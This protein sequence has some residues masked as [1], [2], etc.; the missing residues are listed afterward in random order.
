MKMNYAESVDF[1]FTQLAAYQKLGK[2][3]LQFNLNNITALCQQIENPQSQFKSIHIAG[4]NGK[5]STAHALAAILQANG[6]KVGLF[7]SP[8]YKDLREQIKINGQF[9]DKQFLTDFVNTNYSPIAI[10]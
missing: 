6:L 3:A 4:T 7:T 8:H 10:R 5:G 9:I 2:K 1:I